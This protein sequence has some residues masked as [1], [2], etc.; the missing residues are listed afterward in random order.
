M[1]GIFGIVYHDRLSPATRLKSRILLN[2]LAVVSSDRG[3][4]ATGVATVDQDGSARVYKQTVPATTMVFQKPWN[5]LIRAIP[6]TTFAI[7][8]HTRQKSVGENSVA[9]AHPHVFNKLVG[10][11][12]GTITN[13]KDFGPA[14]K[15]Q[16]DSANVLWS[17]SQTPKSQ[18]ESLFL[19]LRGPA[20]WAFTYDGAMYLLRNQEMPCYML[21]CPDLSATVYA[22]TA[23]ALEQAAALARVTCTTAVPLPARILYE[24]RPNSP[25]VH[26]TPLPPLVV[27]A[28]RAD[29]VTAKCAACDDPFPVV[30]MREYP[31]SS[32]LCADCYSTI[33]ET[34]TGEMSVYA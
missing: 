2:F 13:H 26:R 9:N 27:G 7:V 10:T 6:E 25:L 16:N 23:V 22:S 21:F 8:G 4:D 33:F 17:L 29:D 18:W 34:T 14:E 19:Q 15:F 5:R 11:H 20:A 3:N 28:K 24:F 31:L 1:C 30:C 12:N 32:Y